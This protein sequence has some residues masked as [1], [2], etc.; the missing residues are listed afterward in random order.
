MTTKATIFKP[1]ED[2]YGN[3]KRFAILTYEL[4]SK[5]VNPPL[6]LN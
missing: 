5:N 2:G 1:S 6:K 4:I 3:P